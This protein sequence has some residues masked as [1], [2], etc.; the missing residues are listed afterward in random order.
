MSIPEPSFLIILSRVAEVGSTRD[1][2][3]Q[4]RHEEVCFRN[5]DYFQL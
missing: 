4:C 2:N 5:E 3:L 1:V